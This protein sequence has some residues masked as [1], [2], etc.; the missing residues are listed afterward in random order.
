MT[1]GSHDGFLYE[2]IVILTKQCVAGN[3]K[4]HVSDFMKFSLD[5]RNVLFTKITR[6]GH[7]QLIS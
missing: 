4:F 3:V 5:L 2:I 7:H 6:E 1:R